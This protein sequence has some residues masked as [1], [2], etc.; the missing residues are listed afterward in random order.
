M[1]DIN[2]L[3]IRYRYALNFL[4]RSLASDSLPNDYIIRCKYV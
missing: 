1:Y 3:W 2:K 4:T